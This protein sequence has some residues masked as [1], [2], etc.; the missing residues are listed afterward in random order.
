MF[1]HGTLALVATISL[2]HLINALPQAAPVASVPYPNSDL[3]TWSATDV[4]CKTTASKSDCQ[5][6]F[7]QICSPNKDFTKDY[8][9]TVGQCTAV[10]WVDPNNSVPTQD[11]CTA[12]FTQILNAGIGGSLGYNTA[13][14]R[15]TDP[16]YVMYPKNSGTGNCFKKGRDTS[17]VVAANELPNGNSIHQFGNCGTSTQKRAPDAL[18]P[19]SSSNGV[20][21]SVDADKWGQT[22]SSICLAQVAAPSTTNP[23]PLPLA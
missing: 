9:V 5:S 8:L 14:Q 18:E 22:C 23:S 7:S 1:T 19:R 2:T 17:A 16:L 4:S 12:A 15:T 3:Y 11:I 21:C 20:S 6:A 13:G 10:F